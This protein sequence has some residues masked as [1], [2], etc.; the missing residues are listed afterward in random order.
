MTT[1]SDRDGAV[2]TGDFLRSK[3]LLTPA[4]QRDALLGAAVRHLR[5]FGYA[6]ATRTNVLTVPIYRGLFDGML[7]DTLDDVRLPL[8]A[9]QLVEQLRSEIATIDRGQVA[10]RK[11]REAAA[12]ALGQALGRQTKRRYRGRNKPAT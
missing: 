3:P 9:R 6:D 2:D 11:Q 8:A 10:Q 12:H 1:D 7:R 5:T 4:Q